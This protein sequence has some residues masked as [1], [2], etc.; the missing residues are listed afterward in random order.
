MGKGLLKLFKEIETEA[1][2]TTEDIN[3]ILLNEKGIFLKLFK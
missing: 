2:N 3:K 1:P